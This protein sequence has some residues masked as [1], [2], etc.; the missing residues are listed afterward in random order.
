MS[1]RDDDHAPDAVG[2]E[3]RDSPGQ[4]GSPVVADDVSPLDLERVEHGEDVGDAVSQ[5]IGLDVGGFL[6]RAESADIRREHAEARSDERGRLVSPDI[7]RVRKPVE[8]H[9]GGAL[10]LVE[11][12]QLDAV[13][14]HPAHR[15]RA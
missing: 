10:A 8:E 1:D 4:A 5:P 6:R 9:D 3:R 11:H 2:R 15:R 14:L 7:R 13:S 12:G